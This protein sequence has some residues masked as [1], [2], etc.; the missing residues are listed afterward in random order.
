MTFFDDIWIPADNLPL[1]STLYVPFA[2]PLCPPTYD[3]FYA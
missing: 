2:W 1:P 3:L